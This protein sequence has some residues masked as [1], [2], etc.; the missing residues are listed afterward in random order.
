MKYKMKQLLTISFVL[1]SGVSF[2]QRNADSLI[3]EIRAQYNKIQSGLKSCSKKIYKYKD[4]TSNP[5]LIN[6]EAYYLPHGRLVKLNTNYTLNGDDYIT[7]YS[8]QDNSVF[9]CFNLIKKFDGIQIQERTYYDNYKVI[10]KFI[11]VKNTNDLRDFSEIP[12][13]IEKGYFEDLYYING[14]TFYGDKMI[15]KYLNYP[16]FDETDDLDLKI[17][18]VR[19]EYN[20]IENARHSKALKDETISYSDSRAHWWNT[21]YNVYY[22]SHNQIVLL[23]YSFCDEGYCTDDSVYFKDRRPIFMISTKSDPDGKEYQMRKYFYNGQI[24]KALIKEKNESDNKDFSQVQN[25]NDGSDLK[26]EYAIK[27][28]YD[29]LNDIEAELWRLYDAY[30]GKCS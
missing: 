3:I 20:K 1:L 24:I 8:C 11:K 9:F 26:S 7:E 29:I 16:V 13:Q 14:H 5:A 30:E 25:R 19:T 6:F 28:T 22:N 23:I 10:K 18:R 21:T 12:N 2:A 4:S 27:V 17:K 15:E